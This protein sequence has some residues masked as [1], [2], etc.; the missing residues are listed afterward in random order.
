MID[1]PLGC[2]RC[3]TTIRL[4]AGPKLIEA[5]ELF[6]LFLTQKWFP[7]LLGLFLYMMTLG[8]L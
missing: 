7:S 5:F 3:L 2:Y 4:C 6:G 1:D 8:A